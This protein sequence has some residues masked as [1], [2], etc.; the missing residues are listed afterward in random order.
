MWNPWIGQ[1]YQEGGLLLLGE[2]C[3]DWHDEE[4][5]ELRTPPVDH[6]SNSVRYVQQCFSKSSGTMRKLSRA[7]CRCV[8]PSEEQA[9]D[10]WNEVAFTNFVPVSVGFGPK[11]RPSPAAWELARKEWPEL[12]HE[13][14]P[15][16]VIVFGR[17]M[18]ARLPQPHETETNYVRRYVYANK[19]DA[20]CHGTYHPS[21]G[22]SW[23]EFANLITRLT[24]KY[25]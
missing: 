11:L 25:F 2:S 21:F 18:W 19:I 6:P 20:V 8:A 15:R 10:A 17:G 13:V 14:K 7:L 5:G 9:I 12:L 4:T 1:R 22:P 23:V 16:L 24:E 3:Y